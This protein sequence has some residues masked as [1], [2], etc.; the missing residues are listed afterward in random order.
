MDRY[1]PPREVLHRTRKQR[2]LRITTT[3]GYLSHADMMITV[4][5]RD[6]DLL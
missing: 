3:N 5:R 6:S 4:F 1:L 2:A